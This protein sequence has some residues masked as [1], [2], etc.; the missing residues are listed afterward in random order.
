MDP[1]Y[2]CILVG[3]PTSSEAIP[4]SL[5]NTPETQPT[6]FSPEELRSEKHAYK[7]GIARQNVP[8]P[9]ALHVYS[10]PGSSNAAANL[11]ASGSSDPFVVSSSTAAAGYKASELPKLS[12]VASSFTPSAGPKGLSLPASV[13]KHGDETADHR[14]AIP[15]PSTAFGSLLPSRVASP[16]GTEGAAPANLQLYPPGSSESKTFAKVGNFST[17]FNTSRY[18]MVSH[19]PLKTTSAELE[20]V[21]PVSPCRGN[22]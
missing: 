22:L 9:F 17:E 8:P 2:R 7:T 11:A 21:F 14:S 6:A 20:S 3:S 12:P 15:G 16:P 4:G 13:F 10:K 18:L 1:N 19:V 5:Q